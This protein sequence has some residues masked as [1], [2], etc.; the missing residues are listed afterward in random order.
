MET[1]NLLFELL[2]CG[3]FG[4]EMADESIEL[5]KSDEEKIKVLDAAK[6][7]NLGHLAAYSFD[8]AQLVGVNTAIG[9]ECITAQMTAVYKYENLNYE[10][11]RIS[12]LYEKEKIPFILL[13]GAVI[14]KYYPEPWMRSSC[15]IDILVKESDIERAMEAV[16]TKLGFKLLGKTHH[17]IQLS[18]PAQVTFE[19]HFS[20]LGNDSINKETDKIIKEVWNYTEPLEG[21]EYGFRMNDDM[22]WFYHI[23]HLAKHIKNG[24]CGIVPFLDIYI[25]ERDGKSKSKLTLLKAGGLEKVD[26]ASRALAEVYFGGKEYDENTLAL[27]EYILYGDIEGRVENRAAFASKKGGGKLKNAF[28]RVFCPY[29]V[30]KYRYPK[31]KNNKWLF[32]PYQFRRW[33]DI[34]FK[35]GRKKA[36][37]EFKANLNVS[38]EKVDKVSRLRQDLGL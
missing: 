35:G 13:K 20:L 27:S 37:K 22:L 28:K 36:I 1:Y 16:K 8:K 9:Q 26:T 25:M 34:L 38:D 4:K 3:L 14:R 30:L 10:L 29:D 2:R 23:V 6:K 24:G 15:D 5:L 18:S 19:L 12:E 11:Q 32:I 31:L 21:F 7:H 33:F 17:D